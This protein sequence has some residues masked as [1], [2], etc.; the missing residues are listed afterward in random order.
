ARLLDAGL[1]RRITDKLLGPQVI[2]ELLLGDH[3]V[4]LGDEVAQD[5]EDLGA[6]L[7]ERARAAQFTAVRVERIVPKKI[8]HG[9]CSSACHL[10]E[11]VLPADC[12]ETTTKIPHLCHHIIMLSR[13]GRRTFPLP[14]HPKQRIGGWKAQ[15]PVR[16]QGLRDGGYCHSH[17]SCI[18]SCASASSAAF[19]A[20]APMGC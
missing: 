13:L 12:H 1:Q 15:R 14:C 10:P 16:C 8:L 5:V 9:T 19:S 18:G 3:A 20:T 6:E 4:T 2:E 11:N 7:D 17:A